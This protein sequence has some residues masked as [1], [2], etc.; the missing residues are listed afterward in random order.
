MSATGDGPL[1]G[2][3]VIVTRAAAQA[4]PLGELLRAEGAAVVELPLIEIAEPLD[5]GAGL[6]AALGEPQPYDW[7]VVT[8][9]NGARRVAACL[10]DHDCP[11]ARGARFAAVGAA[12]AAALDGRRVDVVAH[13]QIAEGLLEELPASPARALLAQGDRARPLL[14]DGLRERG[15]DVV[16]VVAYR[17]IALQPSS[18]QAEAIAGAEVVTF[19]SPSALRSFVAAFGVDSVPAVASI[20]PQ[21][22]AAAA[23]LGLNVAAE[24]TTHDLPGLV[25]AV[26]AAVGLARRSR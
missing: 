12:T 17:T 8:S 20:G 13:R 22:S 2:V 14:A 9:P 1:S 19:A 5:G 18:E 11:A 7:I 15:W 21:T 16:E 3:T 4:A 26:V 6:V 24:A 25:A 10:A 23:E